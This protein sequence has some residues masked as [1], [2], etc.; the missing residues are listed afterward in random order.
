M[1]STIFN[2]L[3]IILGFGVLIFVHELGHFLAAKWAG[4]RTEAFAIG[5]LTPVVSWRKGVGFAAGSTHRKVVARTGKPPEKLTEDELE[6][7][8]IGETEYSLR[9]LPIGGFVKML[10]QDDTNPNAV[11]TDPRSFNVC[12]IGK[13]MVVISAGVISNLIFAILFFIVAFLAGVRF[14]APVIGEIAPGAPAGLARAV[15]AEE[16][17]AAGVRHLALQSGDTIKS[18]GGEPIETF[19]DVH[20]ATA[21]SRPDEPLELIA[22]RRGLPE[23]MSLRFSMVP[24]K[25][26]VS[27]LL[28]IGIGP[29]ASTRLWAD[30]ED[31]QQYFAKEGIEG[32]PLRQGMRLLEAGGAPIDTF[33][34]FESVVDASGGQPVPTAWQ[35]ED[36]RGARH[37]PIVR[38]NVPVEPEF[39]L[40]FYP[41]PEKESLQDYELGL[42]GFTPLVE[43]SEVPDD[44]QNRGVILVGDVI[45][46]AGSISAPRMKEFREEVKRHES[47][48]IKLQVL[49]EGGPEDLTAPVDRD[50]KLNVLPG[51]ALGLPLTATP[52]ES[53][54]G[55]AKDT[56]PRPTPAALLH[57][58][59][60]TRLEAVNG[61]TI[62]DWA[63]FR[64]LLRRHTAG[65]K[66][67]VALDI[68]HPTP[69]AE[70][71][72]M[73]LRLS[74]QDVASL[75]SLG[76]MSVLPSPLFEPLYTTLDAGGN[77]FT[78]AAMG[79]RRTHRF[80]VLTYLT[81]DRLF[82]G[83]VG[84]EQV[85][86]PVGIVHVGTQIADRGFTYLIFFL[87]I[88]SVNLAV[89]NFLPLPI[90]DGGL[91]L[92][93]IY[94]KLKGRP[95]SLAFQ[96]AATIFGIVLIGTVLLVVTWND[97]VRLLS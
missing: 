85:R 80:I 39:Q 6:R 87:G 46:A 70:R 40:L 3:L 71:E 23:G 8:G 1:L 27:G 66:T 90:V 35:A 51:Y 50:G 96:N 59:G 24:E 49:R 92:F 72:T 34:Q 31:L 47:K 86:G 43:M 95:P 62:T 89:I 65:G 91:F 44:S 69:G 15:N 42:L 63:S 97:V 84:V 78:A 57:L 12:P 55:D 33:E 82:R 48:T 17:Q 52:I 64:E 9:W 83:S 20:I 58:L 14:E 22:S 36:D 54:R 56:E 32:L 38:M 81:I 11:S 67:T 29:A 4:I 16:L 93:L 13:R 94:E 30:D 73:T 79:F 18:I 74:A 25:D 19:A 61:E 7:Y 26:R 37:G 88:I 60:R 10:G 5:M 68:T 53:V 75:Q 21:M 45:L 41:R 28:S 76:W 77:P 2:F